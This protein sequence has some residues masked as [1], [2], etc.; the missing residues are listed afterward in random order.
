MERDTKIARV[1][2][3]VGKVAADER[4]TLGAKARMRG[5]YIVGEG[6]GEWISIPGAART[7]GAGGINENDVIPPVRPLSQR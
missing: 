4:G 5:I 2:A 6:M 7:R 1:C 3:G